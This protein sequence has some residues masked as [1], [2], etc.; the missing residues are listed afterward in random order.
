MDTHFTVTPRFATKMLEKALRLYT[1]S[2]SEKPMAEFLADK[3][4]DLG[5]EDIQIDEVGNVIAKKGSGSPKIMLCGHMDV[6]PGKV[7]VRKEGDSLYGRGASD[8][9]APLMAM[10]FAAAS[11]QN[12]NGTIIFVGAVDEEGNATGIKNLVKKEMDVDYA[13]FGEPSGIKQVTI[14]Y[15]GRLAINLKISVPDSSHASAP[16]LSKNAILESMIF[17]RELKEKLEENQENRT[18][19]MLLTA[20]MTEVKGGTSHNVTPKECETTF[21]IRIPVDMNCKSI[22]Q[23]IANLVKEIAE[24]R[25]VEAFYSIL[26]ETEPFEAA[27]NSPLVRAFTLGVM[28]VEHTRP[29]LIR[30]TGTGDMNV[31]GTQWNIPVVTYGPGDPHEA[32]TIDEKVSIDEYL[33]GIEILKNMLQHLKRL[34]DRKMQ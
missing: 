20:T 10:L 6:V 8:A 4:D 22:E 3:C 16:W 1:P 14:A 17:A 26:D 27:H 33:R 2:L 28:D 18:K 12:N 21:D 32:H 5:F 34:H 15:K 11:I 7:K 23:K 29:K 25:E 13:V 30:K 24:K 9:K 19:G 31:L